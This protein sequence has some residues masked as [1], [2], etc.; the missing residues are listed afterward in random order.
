MQ[1]KHPMLAPRRPF[2]D[3]SVVPAM[4]SGVLV[5][6]RYGLGIATIHARKARVAAL[7]DRLRQHYGVELPHGPRRVASGV[8][9][10][11]GIGPQSW[12]A[13][14]EHAANSVAV[15]LKAA[16]GDAASVVDQSDGYPV[17]RMLG[18]RVRETL[19]KMVPI[20][21][22]PRAFDVGHVAVTGAGHI[23]V[24]LWRLEDHPAGWPVFEMSI[25]RSMVDCFWNDL[26]NCAAEFGLDKVSFEILAD[27]AALRA[28]RA[29]DTAKPAETES[30]G[31]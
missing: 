20:D 17:L 22:H 10:L 21:L 5:A 31:T 18:P 7:A 14:V 9:A 29:P 16:I 27:A 28:A 1:S 6:D 24:S 15:L 12:L 4:R 26:T 19:R 30:T 8:C 25:P 23:G 13:T 11:A 2:A 3:M